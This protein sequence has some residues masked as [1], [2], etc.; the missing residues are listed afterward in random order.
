MAEM[1]DKEISN[2]EA[3][4]FVKEGIN[5]I[6]SLKKDVE[7]A[8]IEIDDSKAPVE[9]ES[10][11]MDVLI[12]PVT[13]ERK[14]LGDANRDEES[15]E[16]PFD[17]MVKKINENDDETPFDNR[18]IT[19]QEAVDY[20]SNNNSE[21]LLNTIADGSGISI[22]STRQLLEVVNRKIKGE[23]FNTY[24][25]LPDEIKKIIDEYVLANGSALGAAN[26]SIINSIKRNAADA[27]LDDFINDIQLD[28]VKND[29]ARDMEQLYRESSKDIADTSLEYIDERN[30][31]YREAANEIEDE[32][33]RNKL[34][35][36][37]D[38]IDA[39]RALVELK[40][41]AKTCK[42]KPIETEKP[43]NRIYS[44]FINKYK[45]STNNIY[46]INIAR[47]VLYRHLK[48]EDYSV[49]E[50][51]SFF[52]LFCKQVQNYSVNKA[53]DHAYMYY[54]LYYC[55]MLDGDKSDIFKNNVKE[56]IENAKLRNP[57]IVGK[58]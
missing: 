52:I 40:E 48:D 19:E 44:G 24:R 55:A 10:R 6:D 16:D 1:F 23:K 43:E 57:F 21:S 18:P 14:I 3:D 33:K 31:A 25:E 29:F 20:L 11:M 38:Q 41:F 2:N 51:E 8:G 49:K 4:D 56:V 36:I 39:A 37:L 28:R 5:F 12:D 46:D 30:K 13:G 32:T 9:L 54:V 35:G 45:N 42:I 27:I 34:L 26:V 15:E 7:E 50:V 58:N 47:S 17:E 53:T 22:E